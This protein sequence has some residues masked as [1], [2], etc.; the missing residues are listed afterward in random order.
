MKIKNL[1]RRFPIMLM[2]VLLSGFVFV[3]CLKDDFE[4]DKLTNPVWEPNFSLPLVHSK[5]DLAKVLGSTGTDSMLVE[6]AN[7]FLTLIYRD[8]FFSQ[9]AQEVFPIVDQSYNRSYS[10]SLPGGMS[11]GDS[12]SGSFFDNIVYVNSNSEIID[13]MYLK[14]GNLSF[15]LNTS[16]NHNA[17]INIVMP[18]V[19]KNGIPLS[20]TI[21]LN[22]TGSPMSNTQNVDLTGYKLVFDHSGGTNNKLPIQYSITVYHIGSPDF[23]PYNFSF[24]M[25]FQNQKYSKMFGYMNQKDFL[26]PMDTLTIAIFKNSWFGNFMLEDPRLIIRILNSFGFPLDLTWSTIEGVNP[27]TPTSMA[28]TG[29]PNPLNVTTPSFVGEVAETS[30]YLDKNNSNIKDVVNI[31]PHYFV[32]MFEGQA[33]PSGIYTPNF[34]LDTS[35]FK[36]GIEMEMPL[37]GSAWDFVIEDTNDLQFDRIDELV[38]INFKINILNGFPID[39][40]MQIFIA[41]SLG[42]PLDSLFSAPQY[43]VQSANVGPAP[44]YRV[45]TP[46]LRYTEVNLSQQ[47]LSN[48]YN[49]R[50]II[51]RATLNTKNNGLD[52]MKIYSDYI[53]DVR[54]AAQ[55]QLRV[56]LNEY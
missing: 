53:I 14:Q 41:D 48:L 5:L 36:V 43:I 40:L 8:E 25:A 55:A 47:R 51:T 26:F 44:D 37:Y 42:N 22:Y 23:S 45:T 34:V 46:T 12:T 17:K 1:S 50:K 3:S 38:Y 10:Y 24:D 19:T 2:A 15:T 11:N 9:E 18:T 28:L 20:A 35:R 52:L 16:L 4:F 56:D 21:P 32:Y 54:L 6:D 39:A 30:Y 13:T 7:H 29:L 27:K 33:N 49:A 31:I